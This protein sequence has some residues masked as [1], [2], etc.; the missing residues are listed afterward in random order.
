MNA[1]M[2]YPDN[3]IW[4]GCVSTSKGSK[5]TRAISISGLRSRSRSIASSGA[6]IYTSSSSSRS[7]PIA[8]S[9][10]LCFS[11]TSRTSPNSLSLTSHY[12]QTRRWLYERCRAF[13]Q[14]ILAVCFNLFT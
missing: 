13:T 14:A 9:S 10:S 5:G 12:E 1:A 4:F 7:R 11:S 8:R 2:L 3:L 6:A